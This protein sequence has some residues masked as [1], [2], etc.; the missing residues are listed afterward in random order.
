MKKITKLFLVFVLGLAIVLPMQVSNVNAATPRREP[1]VYKYDAYEN[2][3]GIDQFYVKELCP[4]NF[5]WYDNGIPHDVMGFYNP[6]YVDFIPGKI[7]D[8]GS[9]TYDSGVL[10]HKF[11]ALMNDGRRIPFW[12]ANIRTVDKLIYG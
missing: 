2:H 5:S 4:V 8:G 1:K 7:A 12:V 6:G 11:I 3:Y 9:E 10:F